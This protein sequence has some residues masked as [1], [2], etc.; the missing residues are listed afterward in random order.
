MG[1]NFELSYARFKNNLNRFKNSAGLVGEN[2]DTQN[3]LVNGPRLAISRHTFKLK[4]F[5]QRPTGNLL[6]QLPVIRG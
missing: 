6:A 1:Q 5:R 2:Q 3:K 4:C